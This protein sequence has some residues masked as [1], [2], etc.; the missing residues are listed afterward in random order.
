MSEN[1]AI[2]GAGLGGL[3]LARVLHVNGIAATIYEAE[4]SASS[5][6]QGGLLDIHTHSG[7]RALR[8]AGLLPSLE[9]LSLPGEDAKRIVD[10]NGALLFDHPGKRTPDRPEVERGALRAMLIAS[11]PAETIRWGHKVTSVR[12]CGQGQ[13]IDLT[14][15]QTIA[16]DLVV[17][18]DG[19]W[20]KVRPLLSKA[21]PEYS[22]TCFIEIAL[23]NG[24]AGRA[25][26]IAAIGHGT[27]MALAPGR[28]IMVH[29]HADG[30]ARGYAAFDKPETWA[31]SIDVSDRRRGLAIVA[32]EFAGWAPALVAFVAKSQTDPV[33]RP[34]YA[35]PIGMRWDRA[36]G[37]T[38]I[39]DAAHLMSPFAGEGANLAMLDGAELA[40]SIVGHRGDITAALSTY[41][42]EMFPRSAAA[43]DA[44]AR[45]LACFFGNASPQ[46]AVKLFAPAEDIS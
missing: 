2:V 29:R 46:S 42:R 31:R 39:G 34:I 8:D 43:A 17:G 10:R 14:D 38:L 25:S 11:L 40:K 23:L 45:N 24:D 15:G 27:L 21:S 20:S 18:A 32:S 28:G 12:A 30:T 3:L 44:S 36:P 35:L 26:S 33:F 4:A 6:A 16:A 22:G 13:A 9:A 37:L 41:E 1:I 7:Q 19:A 5:R